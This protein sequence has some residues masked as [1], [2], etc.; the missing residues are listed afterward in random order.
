MTNVNTADNASPALAYPGPTPEDLLRMPAV[1]KTLPQWVL[2]QLLEAPNAS[3]ELKLNKVPINPRTLHGA[4]STDPKTW[5]TYDAC[6]A[7]LS[8]AR[9]TWAQRPPTSYNKKPATYQGAGLGFVFTA[10]DAF[11]LVDLDKSLDPATGQIAAWAQSIVETL[12]SYTQ[13]SVSGEGLHML[14]AASLPTEDKQHG[15]MQMWDRA[16]F[17]AMT[18]WHLPNTPTTIEARQSQL[19]MV[20]AAHILMPKAQE[21]HQK[22]QQQTR[23]QQAQTRTATAGGPPV[24][25]DQEIVDKLR[26]AKNSAKFAALWSGDKTGYTSQSEADLA[27]LDLLAFYTKDPAQ[28][29]ALFRQSGLCDTKWTDR[30]G[31]RDKTITKALQRVTEHYDP[32]D[33]IAEQTAFKQRSTQDA[34]RR[35][36]GSRPDPVETHGPNP[37]LPLSD[38]TN[39]LAFVRDHQ[40][41]VR[42]LEAWGKWLHWTGTHW[43][44]EVQGP[45]MQKAKVTIKRFLQQAEHLDDDALEK[46]MKHI[47]ASLNK[48]KLEAMIALAQDEPRIDIRLTALNTHPWLLPCANGTLDLQ[49]GTLRPAKRSDYLT[50]CLTTRYD[51]NATCPK[52]DAFLWR[53]MGGAVGNEDADALRA[54]EL[55]QQEEI[56][57]RARNLIR[58]IQRVLGQ[59]LS[60]DVSEQDLYIFYGTGANGKSTLI[61]TILA[62]LAGYAMKATAELLLITRSDRHPTE[63]ADLFGKRL[64]ATI[65]TQEAGRLNETFVKEATGGDPIRAR[66]MREDFWEFLPTHKMILATNHKPE[67]RGTDYAIWRRIKLVPFTVTIPTAEQDKALPADLL[68]ELPGILAWMVR[69]C[70]DWRENG[71][72]PPPDVLLATEAYRQEQDVFEAF[73][74]TECFR[75]PT[76]RVSAADLYQAYEGWCRNNDIEPITKRAFGQRLGDGGFTPDKGT[77]GRRE[78]VGVGLPATPSEGTRYG[79]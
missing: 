42:Y 30:Q 74:E 66:R 26:Q 31:Y 53:I 38:Y 19:T 8:K 55:R 50:D 40:A 47:K 20:H 41:D 24:L 54:D 21:A 77:G 52:W 70:L 16:R 60:G 35:Q 6:V 18:G 62:L 9:T 75:T 4:S 25:T 78:W 17:V 13:R 76:A 65:E 22:A 73:L 29:D 49:R 27:L 7:A 59:C 69:G 72:R 45:I 14:V 28:L 5:A 79:N 56:D 43:S 64:V 34:A 48:G 44:Y 23:R 63:R 58:F 15:N 51:P 68:K 10:A 71:L 12:Q 57:T 67:I 3:G 11:M 33:Y 39:A 1:L 37:A 32:E 46:W 2:W 61:N 36:N